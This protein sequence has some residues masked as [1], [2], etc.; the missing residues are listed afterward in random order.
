MM[1]VFLVQC[2]IDA[3]FQ[4]KNLPFEKK[5][6]MYKMHFLVHSFATKFVDGNTRSSLFTILHQIK[7]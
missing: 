1:I 2:S 6:N 7:L 4:Q 3:K 5:Y